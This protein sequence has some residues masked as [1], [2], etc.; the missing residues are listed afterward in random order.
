LD[1]SDGE[2]ACGVCAGSY[3][4]VAAK[5]THGTGGGGCT[6]A[7]GVYCFF[8]AFSSGTRLTCSA[9]RLKAIVARV[10]VSDMKSRLGPAVQVYRI[11]VFVQAAVANGRMGLTGDL[12]SQVRS[13]ADFWTATE[14]ARVGEEGGC[15]WNTWLMMDEQR[16][17]QPPPPPPSSDDVRIRNRYCLVVLTIA[18]FS[19]GSF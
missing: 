13:F 12:L 10:A 4:D 18:L 2:G 14:A 7:G 11:H 9:G 16:K 3:N 1:Y 15:G 17:L 6:G 19:F 5:R 8:A